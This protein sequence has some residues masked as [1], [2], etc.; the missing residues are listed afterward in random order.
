MKSHLLNSLKKQALGTQS[1]YLELHPVRPKTT[2]LFYKPTLYSVFSPQY[3]ANTSNGYTSFLINALAGGNSLRNYENEDESLG[4]LPILIFCMVFRKIIH[5][6][7]NPLLKKTERVLY[8]PAFGHKP[9]L[10]PEGDVMF[11]ES[12]LAVVVSK[13]KLSAL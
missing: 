12:S 10:A 9:P 7:G 1:I 5:S 8:G 4:P 2:L 6:N 3:N 13:N 11:A